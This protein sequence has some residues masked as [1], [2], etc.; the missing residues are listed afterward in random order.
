MTAFF[1]QILKLY[2]SRITGS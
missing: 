1:T 2:S